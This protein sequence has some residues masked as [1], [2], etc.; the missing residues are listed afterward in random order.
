M[1][2][3]SVLIDRKPLKIVSSLGIESNTA[4][5]LIFEKREGN[6]KVTTSILLSPF[7]ELIDMHRVIS[8]PV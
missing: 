5:E 4:Q 7:G 8:V 6:R 2:G 1:A 3:K